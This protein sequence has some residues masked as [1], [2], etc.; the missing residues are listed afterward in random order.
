MWVG[1]FQPLLRKCPP[2]IN[3]T[4]PASPPPFLE[5]CVSL[6]HVSEWIWPPPLYGTATEFT[7]T[8]DLP[9]SMHW[10]AQVLLFLRNLPK[11]MVLTWL[12]STANKTFSQCVRVLK[13]V[14]FQAILSVPPTY[15]QAY[16]EFS[17][18]LSIFLHKLEIT[19]PFC[20]ISCKK[21]HR[22]CQNLLLTLLL[23]SEGIGLVSVSILASDKEC[24]PH[25]NLNRLFKYS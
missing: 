9:V 11:S 5:G 18:K 22:F 10:L 7:L 12:A 25:A 16:T 8:P 17:T 6:Q 14:L 19:L 21:W 13:Q 4:S 24:N 2:K 15:N 3:S 23:N 1:S 20:R